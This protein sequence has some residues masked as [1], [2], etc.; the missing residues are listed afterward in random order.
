MDPEILVRVER[1]AERKGNFAAPAYFWVLRVLEFTRRRLR[2]AGHVS[3][4]ELAVGARD[5]ALEEYGPMAL[6]VLQHWGL[7]TT[8]DIG[9]IVYDLIEEEILKKTEEDS[10]D[11]FADVYEF[12][13]AFLRDDP[14]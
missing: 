7:R 2:R 11:D 3:G 13:E 14:W 12:R 9:R 5:L 6:E 4:R 8:T 1:L 10:L